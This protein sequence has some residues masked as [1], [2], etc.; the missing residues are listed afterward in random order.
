MMGGMWW[1][2][3]A[4]GALPLKTKYIS[5]SIKMCIY[6]YTHTSMCVHTNTCV[7]IDICIHIRVHI[8]IYV[9]ACMYVYVSLFRA[10]ASWTSEQEPVQQLWGTTED[11]M[12]CQ[13]SLEKA[14]KSLRTLLGWQ[15]SLYYSIV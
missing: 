11:R 9:Y 15:L 7:R 10:M 4:A 14:R 1:R 3:A 13:C 12:E 5:I 6:V 2:I 8:C